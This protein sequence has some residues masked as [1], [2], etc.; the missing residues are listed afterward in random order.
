MQPSVKQAA[1]VHA[2]LYPAIVCHNRIMPHSAS[3]CAKGEPLEGIL[4]I[5]ELNPLS[6]EELW[7]EHHLRFLLHII[8]T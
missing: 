3:L 8:N 5:L 6:N 2:L 1:P 7:C 4:E